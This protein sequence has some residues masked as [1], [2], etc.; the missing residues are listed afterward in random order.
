MRL[1]FQRD[2]QTNYERCVLLSPKSEPATEA[3]K[4]V[5]QDLLDTLQVHK[6]ECVGMAANII[7]V[8][9]KSIPRSEEKLSPFY[10][11]RW[12]ILRTKNGLRFIFA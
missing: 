3:D 5:G 8:K 2:D 6:Q 11:E 4:Q 9:K 10:I 12:L 1:E 7:G